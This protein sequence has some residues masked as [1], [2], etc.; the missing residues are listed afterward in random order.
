M[1]AVLERQTYRPSP[2]LLR[3]R[4][5][6][7]AELDALSEARRAVAGG[8]AARRLAAQQ[9][10][11]ALVVQLAAQFQR[12]C[13][14]L[15]SECS[16][17]VVAAAPAA[18]QYVLDELLISGRKLD[19]LSAQPASLGSDFARFGLDLWSSVDQLDPRHRDRRR[20]LT[21]VVIWRNAIAHQDLRR[22]S[23]D[24]LTASTAVD[25]ATVALW[26]RALDQLAGGLDRAMWAQLGTIVGR[27]PW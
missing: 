13:R 25:P 27:P 18:Y 21:Q 3:W 22:A 1:H 8:G 19:H 6:G 14:D 7:R 10:T 11:H 23:A 20:R 2:P 16:N 17:V 9:V 4:T 24:P 12:F 5:T 15:H 26:R